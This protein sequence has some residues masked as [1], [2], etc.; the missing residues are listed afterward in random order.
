MFSMLKAANYVD[1]FSPNPDIDS[2]FMAFM[3]ILLGAGVLAGMAGAILGEEGMLALIL[4]SALAIGGIIGINVQNINS[5]NAE[6]EIIK[7]MTSNI[8]DKYHADL[9][10]DK[11]SDEFYKDLDKVK[12]YVL[13]FENGASSEYK[14]KFM[15]SGEPVIVEEA[16]APSIQELNGG[17]PAVSKETSEPTKTAAPVKTV[18]PK[19]APTPAELEKSAQK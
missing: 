13:T 6:Q 4:G 12:S 7:G 10:I 2:G 9:T 5:L 8:E 1:V 3:L 16:E 19:T 11:S 15:K 14:I 18:E 17:E